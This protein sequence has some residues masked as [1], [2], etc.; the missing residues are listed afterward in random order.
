MSNNQRNTSMVVCIFAVIIV[1]AIA[2]G[3]LSYYG[4]SWFNWSSADTDFYFDAEVGAT[5]GTVTLDIDLDVGG[6]SITFVDNASLLYD[7]EI[8]VQNTTLDTDGDPTVTFTSNTIGLVYT[9]A[10][11]NITLGSGVNYTLDIDTTT[12]GISVAL[13]DG[14]HVGDVSLTTEIGGITL[15]MTDDVVL[16]GNATFDLDSTTGGV[17]VVVDVPTGIGGSVEAAVG[18]GGVDITATGWTEIT[19]NHYET[20]DYDT[21]SQTLTVIIETTTGGITAIFT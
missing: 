13:V 8:V 9:A 2:V 16:L 1:G 11:V 7:I 12:G 4:T 19:S 5:T 20:S 17:S 15:A 6:V 21:A 3:A 10:G 18:T 14:A